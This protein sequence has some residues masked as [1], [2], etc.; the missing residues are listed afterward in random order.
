MENGRNKNISRF[1]DDIEKITAGYY[2]IINI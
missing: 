2:K 1:I